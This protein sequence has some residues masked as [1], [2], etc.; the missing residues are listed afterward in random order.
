MT[1]LWR[2]DVVAE[3]KATIDKPLTLDLPASAAILFTPAD[4]SLYFPHDQ[5]GV[6]GGDAMNRAS[7][8]G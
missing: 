8:A 2:L 6:H 1:D 7:W 4:T 3:D 5:P